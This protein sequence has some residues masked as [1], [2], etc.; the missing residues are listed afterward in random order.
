MA[1]FYDDLRHRKVISADFAV[2][3]Q[4][5][6][7]L[8]GADYSITSEGKGDDRTYLY[9]GE[10]MEIGDFQSALTS[11]AADSFTDEQPSQKEEIGLTVLLDNENYP[12]VR[13]EL[14]RY[15]GAHCLAVVDGEPVS[16]VN[17]SDV[18]DLIEARQRDRPQLKHAKPRFKSILGLPGTI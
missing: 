17:R 15:D 1:V 7:S 14:H 4:V 16:L 18:V 12:E 6:I 9:Q 11:L 3:L 2:I 8:E 13:I 10:E 5:Y